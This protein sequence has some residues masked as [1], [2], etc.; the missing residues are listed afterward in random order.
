[1][2]G[3]SEGPHVA[4]AISALA[5][6]WGGLSWF[7]PALAWLFLAWPCLGLV[8]LGLPGVPWP[9][10]ASQ[11]T[12]QG[13]FQA[14]PRRPRRLLRLFFLMIVVGEREK[15]IFVKF[16]FLSRRNA[17]FSVLGRSMLAPSWSQGGSCGAKFA[18]SLHQVGTKLVQVR[19]SWP[20]LAPS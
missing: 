20:K 2:V 5:L 3:A 9:S 4:E 16:A 17:N 6:P 7:G 18:P 1:M 12:T 8:F 14:S 11:K 19:P 15:C 13:S 10:K